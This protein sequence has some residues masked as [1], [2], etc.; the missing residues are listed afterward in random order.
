MKIVNYQIAKKLHNLGFIDTISCIGG[1]NYY[2]YKGVLNGDCKDELKE[3][4][5]SKRE[6]REINP[7]FS[8]ISAPL[9]QDVLDWLRTKYF[10]NIKIEYL[11]S[12]NEILALVGVIDFMI[13]KHSKPDIHI[14]STSFDYYEVLTETILECLNIIEKWKM[15]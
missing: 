7:I 11:C 15:N 5:K 10:I 9:F 1:K 8:N 14:Q 2:N 3:Y 4:F 12:V 6:N 13:N